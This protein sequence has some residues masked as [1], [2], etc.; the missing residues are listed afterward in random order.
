MPSSFGGAGPTLGQMQA[1]FLAQRLQQHRERQQQQEQQYGTD[2]S[3]MM[4]PPMPREAK[5]RRSIEASTSADEFNLDVDESGRSTPLRSNSSGGS[6]SASVSATSTARAAASNPFAIDLDGPSE[7]LTGDLL[8]R[9]CLPQPGQVG[10]AEHMAGLFFKDVAASASPTRRTFGR[11]MSLPS[12]QDMSRRAQMAGGGDGGLHHLHSSAAAAGAGLGSNREMMQLLRAQHQQL[13]MQWQ[14]QAHAK[15]EAQAE[16]EAESRAQQEGTASATTFRLRQQRRSELFTSSGGGSTGTASGS[17]GINF[18][19]SST[20][21]PTS[22]SNGVRVPP[23]FAFKYSLSDRSLGTGGSIA[24][25]ATAAATT[26]ATAAAADASS[27]AATEGGLQRF[28][29]RPSESIYPTNNEVEMTDASSSHPQGGTEGDDDEVCIEIHPTTSAA[30][31]ATAAVHVRP[32]V[33]TSAASS[34]SHSISP[35]ADAAANSTI[36]VPTIRFFN[37]GVEVNETGVPTVSPPVPAK[38]LAHPVKIPVSSRAQRH[39]TNGETDGNEGDVTATASTSSPCFAANNNTPKEDEASLSPPLSRSCSVT[40]VISFAVKRVPELG[41]RMAL[42]SNG[43][44]DPTKIDDVLQA[45]YA[46]A[47]D[48]KRSEASPKAPAETD[49]VEAQQVRQAELLQARLSTTIRSVEGYRRG[50]A[51][52]VA[53]EK[54]PMGPGCPATTAKATTGAV[55]GPHA[56]LI[57]KI[58]GGGG[59]QKRPALEDSSESEST[60]GESSLDDMVRDSFLQREKHVDAATTLLGLGGSQ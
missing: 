19:P 55:V 22:T 57:N 20:V 31:V 37:N 48:A 52:Q 30:G 24:D 21:A 8:Q 35:E 36:K 46:I 59:Q 44:A 47:S 5:R 17:M 49:A 12:P 23:P 32:T 10:F 45:L 56:D 39:V 27:T 1:A 13:Q 2:A 16:A 14:A 6:V 15:A 53:D 9:T 34:S 58:F 60:F 50:K 11:R 51:A 25:A 28:K 43:K 40:D 38:P 4:P 42:P 33:G 26:T 18:S 3:S 41:T 54:A 29:K 7:F